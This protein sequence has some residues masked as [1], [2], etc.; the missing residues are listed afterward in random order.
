M[1]KIK[2]KVLIFDSKTFP[3]S[4]IKTIKKIIS[5]NIV[6]IKT[7]DKKKFF[8][9]VLDTNILINCPRNFFNEDLIKKF[10]KMEW[11]HTAAAGIEAYLTPSF[12]KSKILFTNGKI[13]QG[14]EVADHAVSLLLSLTRNIKF[15]ILKYKLK[16]VKRPIELFKKKLLIVG[17]GGIGSCICERLSGFGMRIDVASEDFPVLNSKVENFFQINKLI[18]IAKNYDVIISAAPL[19][20]ITHKIFSKQFFSSMK[21]NSIFINV[22]RGKLVDTK[23]LS[24]NKILDKF[25]GV[26]LDV[27][28]PEPLPANHHL[29]KKNNI[30]ITDHTAG[31]SDHN[32]KRAYDLIITN[33][34]RYSNNEKL[35]NIVDKTAGY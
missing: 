10:K 13:L 29:R 1:P 16:S 30:I 33:L 21:K 4:F 17:Y 27:T 11:V 6:V 8:K 7:N 9:E 28:D 15:H 35:F 20:R 25:W 2:K 12:V 19:T 24:N 26:G 31:L 32:R 22:S 14:P 34:K 3:K 5:F 18:S 23:A